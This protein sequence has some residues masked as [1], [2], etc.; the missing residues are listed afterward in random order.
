MR[1]DCPDVTLAV[2]GKMGRRQKD[3]QA[4]LWL[5]G[6]LAVASLTAA[7]SAG[8]EPSVSVCM[9]PTNKGLS[10]PGTAAC[11]P[12]P[13]DTYCPPVL[14][15]RSSRSRC[16]R[17]CFLRR[18]LSWGRL[19]PSSHGGPSVC[20]ISSCKDTSQ[21]LLGGILMTSLYLTHLLKD[22]NTVAC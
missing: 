11:G 16:G 9:R 12:D 8:S 19:H 20:L 4:P 3:P 1:P 7:G 5:G 17:G 6:G 2:G 10:P 13:T 18:P 21:I 22:P 14:E 15:S